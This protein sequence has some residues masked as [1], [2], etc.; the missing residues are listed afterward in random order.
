MAKYD[1]LSVESDAKTR[2][3][4]DY[5]WLTA[6]LFL[7]PAK[8]ADGIHNMCCGASEEC[9]FGCLNHSGNAEIYPH[10]IA[11][12][13]NRTLDYIGDY[14]GFCDQLERD[15]DKLIREASNRGLNPACR[16][17]GTSDRPRHARE[18]ARRFP[19][20]QFYDY[21][22]L[23]RPWERTMGNYHLTYSHSGTNLNKCL[24]ALEHGTNVAVVFRGVKPAT[25]QGVE[26]IDGDAHDLR[27]LDPRGV[28]V[29][30]REKGRAIQA[31]PAGGFV[32]IG[33][34]A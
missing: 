7:A 13:I 3:G 21:T 1:L 15:I 31:L 20:V 9:I 28:I 8:S 5:G 10:V 26:V 6:I 25:W 34:V 22:K 23:D 16:L 24:R 27:F 17:N 33:G 14:R 4:T 18:L 2:K 11:G 32:Q 12:R 19:G 29:G 30:L